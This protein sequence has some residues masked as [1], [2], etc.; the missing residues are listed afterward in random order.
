MDGYRT[1]ASLRQL[2]PRNPQFTGQH[3]EAPIDPLKAFSIDGVSL[4]PGVAN[5]PPGR[6]KWVQISEKERGD[7][8]SPRNGTKLLQMGHLHH[9]DQLD[10]IEE[11][12][13]EG[14][15]PVCRQRDAAL[16]RQA[17]GLGGRGTTGSEISA[18][19]DSEVSRRHGRSDDS[20]LEHLLGI[21]APA[22]V[23]GAEKENGP[24]RGY[25][26]YEGPGPGPSK[27][28]EAAIS[29]RANCMYGRPKNPAKWF[30]Q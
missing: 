7:G 29:E 24:R 25:P 11:I 21:G 8:A 16:R 18:R 5:L 14:A 27:G 3:P 6:R 22:Y 10:S 12:G 1:R 13:I 26:S 30:H 2:G 28:V 19:L 9:H 17:H 15:R 20:L 4:T 23:P